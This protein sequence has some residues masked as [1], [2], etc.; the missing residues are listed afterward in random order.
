MKAIHDLGASALFVGPGVRI[1]AV[2]LVHLLALAGRF[3]HELFA[4]RLLVG[5][6]VP[7]LFALVVDVGAVLAIDELHAGGT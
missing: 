3:W 6:V 4:D 5:F 2:A 7:T 1:H